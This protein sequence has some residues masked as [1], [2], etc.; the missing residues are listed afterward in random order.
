MFLKVK[1]RQ[2]KLILILILL[3]II[4]KIEG[5]LGGFPP[6]NSSSC[7]F[8]QLEKKFLFHTFFI[9][10]NLIR[11]LYNHLSKQQRLVLV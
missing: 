6:K 11:L 2:N 4:R 8:V 3:K 10:V 1:L 7:L 9:N 5:F